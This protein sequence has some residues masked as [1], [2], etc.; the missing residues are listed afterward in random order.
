[1]IAS[2]KKITERGLGIE[3]TK[4]GIDTETTTIVRNQVQGG[5]RGKGIETG[6]TKTIVVKEKT[7]NAI[8]NGSDAVIR[9][10]GITMI[11]IVIETEIETDE[12]ASGNEVDLVNGLTRKRRNT[13]TL[14]HL[15]PPQKPDVKKPKQPPRQLQKEKLS[16]SS[17]GR[18]QSCQCIRQRTIPSTMLI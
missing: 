17:P 11:L 15:L 2:S 13:A 12:I 3:G 10:E 8:E 7:V 5:M 1:M 4:T 14:A 16:L 9:A 6:E 18:S